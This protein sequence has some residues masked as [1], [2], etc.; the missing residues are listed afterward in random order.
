MVYTQDANTALWLANRFNLARLKKALHTYIEIVLLVCL[1]IAFVGYHWQAESTFQSV[2]AEPRKS[3]FFYIDYRAL[4]PSSDARFRYVP[5]KV[6]SVDE[7]GIVFKV[8]N[9][10]HTKPVSPREHAKFDRAMLMRNYYRTGERF[11]S[12][13]KIDSL[14]GSGAIYTAARPKNVYISG[15]IVIAEHEIFQPN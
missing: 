13:Q 14:V 6:L 11:I 1:C 3:D 12:H 8:G 9:I 4:D 5:M 15:W 7:Q 10:A 2:V